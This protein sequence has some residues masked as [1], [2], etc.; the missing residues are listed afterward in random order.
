M[1]Q[2]IGSV[3]T[4]VVGDATP[5]EVAHVLREEIAGATI[6]PCI[7]LWNHETEKAVMVTV[8]VEWHEPYHPAV[9]PVL[10]EPFQ[11]SMG[12]WHE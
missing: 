1:I 6:I 12:E 2:S 7:G 11:P 10:D 5:A 4:F 9:N 3:W 8:P